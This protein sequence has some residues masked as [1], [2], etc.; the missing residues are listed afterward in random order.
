MGQKGSKEA[1][2]GGS[3]LVEALVIDHPPPGV[4]DDLQDA[5]SAPSGGG[6]RPRSMDLKA[7]VGINLRNTEE[8]V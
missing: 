2:D 8:A 3:N 1:S 7:S 5:R 6:G 4:A